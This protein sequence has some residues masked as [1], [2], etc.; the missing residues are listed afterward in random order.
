VPRKI[1]VFSR[2]ESSWATSAIFAFSAF[3]ERFKIGRVLTVNTK[4]GFAAGFVSAGFDSLE[5]CEGAA[6][7]VDGF[8]A[9]DVAKKARHTKMLKVTPFA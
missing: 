8:C 1:G 7:G 4:G 9:R 3:R 6:P 2:F 5:V